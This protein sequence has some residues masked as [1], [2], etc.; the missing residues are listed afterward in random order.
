MEPVRLVEYTPALA[1]QLAE[2]WNLSGDNWGGF[3]TAYT[4]E[5]VREEEAA[6]SA[7]NVYLA[8][9]GDEVVGYCSLFEYRED[10]GSLYVQTLNVRP[11][12]HN[13]KI[14]KMLVMQ[15]VERTVELGWPRVDLYTWPGNTKAVPLYK[16]CGFFWERRD[17]V[18]HLMNFIPTVLA[19]EAVQDFF[20]KA[21]W[22]NDAKR[23]IVIEP[24]GRMGQDY[25]LYEYLWEKDGARLRMEFERRARGLR[26]IE[27]DDYL[28]RALVENQQLVFGRRY[29]VTFEVVNKSGRPLTVGIQGLDDKNIQFDMEQVASVTDQ[30]VLTG[31]FFVGEIKEEIST[32]RTHPAV[33]AELTVNGKKAQFQLGIVPKPPVKLQLKLLGNEAVKGIEGTL[34]L[35]MENP[36]P[37][38]ANFQFALPSTEMVRF[39]SEDV[40]V[41]L[42]AKG[43]ETLAI[44]YILH[45]YTFYEAPAHVTIT[46]AGGEVIEYTKKLSVGFIG[47]MGCVGGELP[48]KWVIANGPYRV[49]LLK[50]TNMRLFI[51]DQSVMMSEMSAVYPKLGK[52]YS[53]EFS[54]KSPDRVEIYEDGSAVILRA[55]YASGD[56][57]GIEVTCV[58]KLYASGVSENWTEVYNPMDESTKELDLLEGVNFPLCGAVIPYNGRFISINNSAASEDSLMY[59]ASHFTENWMFTQR[60]YGVRGFVWP[61]GMMQIVHTPVMEH[62]LGEIPGK[63]RI[64][65]ESFYLALGG[66]LNWQEFRAFALGTRNLPVEAVTNN[67][68]VAVN[69]G[70]P[71][72]SEQFSLM[73][74]DHKTT[75]FDGSIEITGEMVSPVSQAFSPDTS[76]RE[77]K[78]DLHWQ[79][80]QRSGVIQAQIDLSPVTY[81]EER[82]V[83]KQS[84][85]EVKQVMREEEGV[86]VWSADN[87]ILQIRMAPDFG[88]VLYSLTYEGREWL[89]SAFPVAGPRSWFNPWFGGIVTL[90]K[91]MTRRS[92]GCEPRT[93]EFVEKVDQCKNIWRG[94]RVNINIEDVPQYKGLT[95]RHHYL[96]LPGVPVLC[97][98]TEL[99][100]N[101][102]TLLNKTHFITEVF[103]KP[104]DDD[105]RRTW[106]ATKDLQGKLIKYKSGGIANDIVT[107]TP[108]LF[109]G[110]R[111][112]EKLYIYQSLNPIAG[113][114]ANNKIDNFT[115]LFHQVN[116]EQG[117]SL[118]MPP[119][120]FVF[121]DSYVPE[122][123]LQDL[124]NVRF[125]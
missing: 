19:T 84:E 101:T 25:D 90:P 67:I 15:C 38:T 57:S 104:D 91:D 37:V 78:F 121:T 118:F 112:A 32:W 31:T 77:A 59:E 125:A 63:A 115:F 46:M 45:D 3:S 88:P 73:V 42:P 102:G 70:N 43:K 35:E 117:R 39:P 122:E 68:E 110:Q 44:P 93:C 27:T 4:E 28:I 53:S 7:L 85:H 98:T 47:R 87:G 89:D 86:P 79:N 58:T 62:H 49:E 97:Y 36:L 55:T 116:L 99:V 20:T 5:T 40:N 9:D 103:V 52:P 113:M 12:Y 54:K 76:T 61:K 94:V 82:Y 22:Y 24:D 21:H 17:D 34:Y 2:M 100:Q 120:F 8:M 107:T 71:F 50:R 11:D 74:K 105:V 96:L 92:L 48:D 60:E 16:K 29:P 106:F 69:G 56:F 30:A 51:L 123:L 108:L 26:L 95:L 23:T 66:F 10:E 13:K 64:R 119:I 114:G 33:T 41:T 1:K 124:Q 109:G 65:T 80:E 83:F 75:C 14:G 6:S 72:V 81:V 111:R 18:T